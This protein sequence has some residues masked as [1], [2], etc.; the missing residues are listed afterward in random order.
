M[1]SGGGGDGSGFE[2]DEQRWCATAEGGDGGVRRLK[3]MNSGGGGDGSGFEDDE[4][5]WCAT[6]EGGDGGVRRLKTMNSG[7]RGD[8]SGFEDDEQRWCATVEGGDGGVR[9]LKTMNSG[10]EAASV[11]AAFVCGGRMSRWIRATDMKDRYLVALRDGVVEESNGGGVVEAAVVV[12]SGE[13]QEIYSDDLIEENSDVFISPNGTKLWVP[14]VD[15]TLKPVVGSSYTGLVQAY[16]FYKSYAHACG[17]NVRI[18][19]HKKC[20]IRGCVVLKYFRCNRSGKPQSKKK[21]DSSTSCR[22]STYKRNDCQAHVLLRFCPTKGVVS[23]IKFSEGHNHSLVEGFNTDLSKISRKLSFSTQKFIHNMSLNSVGPVKAHRYMVSMMGGHHN[24]NGT[25]M[26]FKNFSK[27]TRM[28]I[29]DRD[30]Q[31]VLNRLNERARMLPDFYLDYLV[32]EG[33]LRCLFWADEISKINYEAFGDVLAFDA[34]YQTNKYNM[35]FVPFTGVD[36]HR[37]CVTFGAGLLFNE[38]TESYTWLLKNF[39]KAHK[40]EPMLVLTDQDNSMRAAVLAVFT[41]AKHKLCMWHIMKKLP[42]K[43]KGDL[44]QNTDVRAQL[45]RLVWSNYMKTSTFERKWGELIQTFGLGGNDWLAEMYGIRE[46]WIPAYFR[47]VPMSCLL[48]TTSV[49][50]SSNAAFKVSS[51]S[52]HTLVQFM[53]CFETRLESQRYKQRAADF[54]TSSISYHGDMEMPIQRHAFDVYTQTIFG[55]VEKEINE[56]RYYCYISNTEVDGSEHVYSVCQRSTS[57]AVVYTFQVHGY[58]CNLL[59][60]NVNFDVVDHKTSCSCRCFERIGYLCRHIFYVFQVNH[61]H[62]IPSLYISKRWTRNVLPREVYAVEKRYGVDNSPISVL[63]KELMELMFG[64]VDDLR[65]DEV[66]MGVLAERLRGLRREVLGDGVGCLVL[67]NSEA[68]VVE[69]LVG[70]SMNVDV[71]VGN[72]IGVRTKGCGRK[73][74]ITGPGEKASK[75]PPKAPRQCKT[76]M[77]YVTDHDSRNCKMKMKE[78]DEFED[79]DSGSD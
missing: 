41:E 18:G 57:T 3:T 9:R 59:L 24:V 20:R 32:V 65:S 33:K 27:N 1:N 53:L 63:R 40:K 77:L 38:T 62:E 43:I 49:C 44:L 71:E 7:G 19:Q 46:R 45:H 22:Q 26:D 51:T 60:K 16:N 64:F 35:V 48:K 69:E 4:Q 10:G 34:T 12:V 47:D 55:E 5:R 8:G 42:S 29:G 68:E 58:I 6:A 54:K 11:A 78:G 37:R 66:G 14:K 36:N 52:A 67:G 25:P 23:V 15:E 30:S 28:F 79:V 56:A 61:V 70:Q 74:R 72:P 2:D 75:K 17:F 73:R 31:L 21:F 39:L 13:H 76:C 50:E